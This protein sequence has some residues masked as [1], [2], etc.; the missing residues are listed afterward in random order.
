MFF[1]GK[2]ALIIL[3][4]IVFFNFFIPVSVFAAEE[5]CPPKDGTI[6]LRVNIPGVTKEESCKT[7]NV[8][9]Y[10]IIDANG[11]NK[12][13]LT[14]FLALI[15]KF[16]VGIAG[17]AAVIMMMV[18]GY[19][20]LFSGGNAS[21]VG[22]AKSI[23]S[24]AVFGLVLAVGSYMVMNMI[25]PD[26][27]N[28]KFN[29]NIE[30]PNIAQFSGVKRICSSTEREDAIKITGNSAT[31]FQC[32]SVYYPHYEKF[33][34]A[35]VNG[36]E[37]T[38]ECLGAK[39]VAFQNGCMDVFCPDG[40]N[41]K[42]CSI[43]SDEEGSFAF[44]SCASSINSITSISSDSFEV[45]SNKITV[46][47]IADFIMTSWASV[48]YGLFDDC[49]EAES[50]GFNSV[51]NKC[52]SKEKNTCTLISENKSY[53]TNV[54]GFDKVIQAEMGNISGVYKGREGFPMGCRNELMST[55][56]DWKGIQ[57]GS[58]GTKEYK[59]TISSE[60]C[61]IYGGDWVDVGDQATC[62]AKNVYPSDL[63]IIWKCCG[64]R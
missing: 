3:T 31:S 53:F 25:N 15:Y 40:G 9:F 32:G 49:G 60:S 30:K 55:I 27:V 36:K 21:R 13:D 41:A 33:Q 2:R 62:R 63:S 28:W 8:K 18:G 1:S 61:S 16:L 6:V 52:S 39:I 64:H 22:E 4:S 34:E 44:G 57:I 29:P 51:S 38:Q 50:F 14:D 20:W 48:I 5:E 43:K 54:L 56:K 19:Y 24:G 59:W 17:I 45:S 47:D 58:L 46:T 7:G 26:L 10:T 11:D 42:I 23:L 37:K 12:G 35:C